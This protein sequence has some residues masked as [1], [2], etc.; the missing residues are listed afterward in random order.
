MPLSVTTSYSILKCILVY[1]KYVF[2]FILEYMTFLTGLI[3]QSGVAIEIEFMSH[4][5]FPLRITR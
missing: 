5:G 1:M 2:I 3:F 4:M